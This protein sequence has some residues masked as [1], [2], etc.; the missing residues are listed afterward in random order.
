[1]YVDCKEGIQ[2][3]RYKKKRDGCRYIYKEGNGCRCIKKGMDA[4]S[5]IKKL[6]YMDI[7]EIQIYE[8]KRWMQIYI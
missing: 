4:A 5:Y 7:Y 8:E 6:L 2:R 3:Y 1:M